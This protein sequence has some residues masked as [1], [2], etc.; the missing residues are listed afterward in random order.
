VPRLGDAAG[1]RS[2]WRG[3]EVTKLLRKAFEQASELPPEEQD[4]VARW[5][6]EELASERG[7]D[8]AFRGSA[9][10]L[11]ELADEALQEAREGR[12]EELDPDR[13]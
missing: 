7:W 2:A 4:A 13:L 9:D 8:S 1:G 12:T 3:A 5:L 6:L 11:K 10:R